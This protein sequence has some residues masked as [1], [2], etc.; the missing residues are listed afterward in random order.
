MCSSDLALAKSYQQPFEQV[1]KYYGENDLMEGLR[2]Q[3]RE[4]KAMV[5][6]LSEAVI[7][8]KDK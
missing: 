4:D 3:L 1:K 2:E 7:S 6:L 5:F 8:K